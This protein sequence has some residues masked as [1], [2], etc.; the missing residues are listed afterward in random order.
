MLQALIQE[1]SKEP[2]FESLSSGV[3]AGMKE[4]LISGLAGSS[5][6]VM[7]AA[8]HG[9]IDRPLLVVTHNMFSAQR[10][11]EDLQEALNPDQVLLY[12][13]NEL[14][15]AESAVSSPE[16]LAQRIEVLLKCSQGFRGIVVVPFSGVRRYVPIASELARA[17][18]EVKVGGTLSLDA[19][20]LRLVELGYDRVQ[21]VE[22][23]G[24]MSV[25][26]GIIDIYPLTSKLAYR[27]ELFDE[28]VDSI[29]TFDPVDQ[30]SVDQVQ[31]IRIPPCKEIIAP[32][33][34]LD[35]AA[36]TLEAR[37]KDQLDK[38][39]DRQAKIRLQEEISRDVELLREHVNFSEMYK[40]ISLIYP[41]EVTLYDYMPEDTLLILDEPARL[42]ETGKQLERDEAEWNLHLFQNSKSLPELPLSVNSDQVLYQRPYQTLFLSLFL[43]QVPHVQPQNILNFVSRAM[44][45]F[46]GQMNVLKSEMERWKKSGARVIMLASNEERIERMRRVLEDYNIDEPTLIQGNM[47]TG[48]ELP[49]I[50]L[51]VI[52]EGEMF[53][54]KQRKARK[55]GR[56]MDNAERIKSYTELKLG[57]Y[58]VHQNHGIGKYI[59]IGTLEVGG[60]HKDYLHILYA[61]GDKLSVPIDQIDLIQK[62]VG[63][64]DKEPKVY[65]LGGNDWIRVKNKVRSSVEDIADELI[66]LYADRQASEGYGFEKDSPEQVEFEAMFPYDET[67][68]QKRAIEE[69][70]KDM[71]K[72]RPMDRL[73]C[74]DVGYGKTEVAIR[75]AFKSAIEGKQVAVL[76]PTTI[77]AQQ[78]YETF[79]ERFSGYPINIQVLSRFRSRKEQNETTKGI[80]QGTVDI[81]IG[82]HRL[83]SQDLVFKDLGL[84]IVDE[85]QR[86]GVTHKEKLKRLKVNV[87]VLT[88]T[89]TPIPRTLHMSMLGV[90]DLSVIETPPE[91]RFPVQ[92]YVV[93]HSHALV[94]ES[95]ERELA[96]GGQV[97][98]LYNKVQ[99]IQEMAA[100]I[101][102]LV[103]EAKVGIGHG[104]MSEQELEKTILDFL[105]G[106][107]DVL[108][109]TSI[110]ETGV[111]IP[112]VNTLI[113]HDADKM[114]LSQLYQLRGRVGRSNRIAYAYF[115][116]QKDK[117]LTEVAEKRLQSIKEFTELGSGFK[118]AMRDLSIRGAGNLLGAEQHGFIASVGFDLYSQMLAE[119][120]QKRK[121]TL[122]GEAEPLEKVW[123][124]VID[125]SI[126]AYL[127]PEYIYDSIQKIEIYKKAAAIES[128]EEATEL[129]DELLDRFGEAPEAVENLLSAAKLKVYS[130]SYG[131]ESITRRG[132]EVIL[133]FHEGREKDL[134]PTKFAEIGNQY[135]RRVQFNQGPGIIVQIKVKDLADKEMMNWLE[136]FLESLKDAFKLKGEVHNVA[137]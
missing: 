63:S 2:D 108:V 60:I 125:L 30:R 57:D 115:T 89:A 113:V 3:K 96:R 111:D 38:M 55:V 75:A 134:I 114:G 5:R 99:G 35:Q 129:A 85:E 17:E 43:R 29:R 66:K 18:V 22:S 72:S 132:D 61:G 34:R 119:E 81:V 121:I 40:Y 74:G 90:R 69:I 107:Y 67:R 46:H 44:Q 52:T 59:G 6:Q 112:N 16:T 102:M 95:I 32:S 58:V 53:S 28:D 103:P 7:L 130:R 70:K 91:N 82:T 122:L 64:E 137:K 88:L 56:S 77:L 68:D 100:Q 124:T 71:E 131:I 123:N 48:F 98:Y 76:V 106:E 11:A 25:R 20:L 116:Y 65:K 37:L 110:I 87:D 136:Q 36:V 4:Q 83:L 26:G 15:A 23:R 14:V 105:D 49:S 1:F 133:K 127:P 104:Q 54:Q 97:Y 93:E 120:I 10:I 39:S 92:T 47:Q 24:E 31:A 13:A 109:S 73:L 8:L 33:E 118:I 19:F 51:V 117:S 62:Y 94:R 78:H 135:G 101:S 9:Q 84:L 12:P 27:I 41:E 80:K 21:R 42:L 45:D 128:L 126:D 50:H 79:R 86:F